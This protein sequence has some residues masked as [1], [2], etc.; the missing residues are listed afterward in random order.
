MLQLGFEKAVVAT[1]VVIHI[2]SDGGATDKS[3]IVWHILEDRS[4]LEYIG[5]LLCEMY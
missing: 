5:E 1:A 4:E 3:I 2:G